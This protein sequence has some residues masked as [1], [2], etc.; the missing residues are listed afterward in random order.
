MKLLISLYLAL[1][2]YF[3][4]RFFG[5]FEFTRPLYVIRDLD[6]LK[7]IEIK[8]F[9]SFTNH[10]AFISEE[11][12]DILF[13]NILFFLKDQKWRDARSTLR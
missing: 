5:I 10:R 3:F 7:Q 11:S 1:S 13:H 2:Q 9:N 8:E 4:R 12:K 6:L